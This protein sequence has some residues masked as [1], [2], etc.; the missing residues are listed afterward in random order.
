MV[1]WKSIEMRKLIFIQILFF[2][3]LSNS[4]SQRID[5]TSFKS[6]E[7]KEIKEYKNE[8]LI[9]ASSFKKNGQLAYRWNIKE[10]VLES[11]DAISYQDT[12]AE[13]F[14]DNCSEYTIY[15]HYGNGP[16]FRIENYL[17]RKRH[18]IYEK[19]ERNG[20]LSV[21][22]QF[23][24][25]KKV[26]IWTYYSSEGKKDR[27]VHWF[28]SNYNSKGI[29]I[30][31]TII[32]TFALLLFI[33]LVGYVI[34]K[35]YSYAW[36]YYFYSISSFLIL[37]SLF[38]LSVYLDRSTLVELNAQIRPYLETIL[39][40]IFVFLIG[41]SLVTTILRKK[42][43]VKLYVSIPILLISIT[44]ELWLI[45]AFELAGIRVV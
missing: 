6:G 45:V 38:V 8:E 1:H 27:H 9:K 18:G 3:S 14:K 24:N 30:D 15:Q 25:W 37:I 44:T 28:H 19:Y 32:P 26:G 21:R 13:Y 41:I 4:Y 31:Y 7:T 29:S 12:L 5:T 10:R 33:V 2:F 23:A 35:I 20:K 34:T 11:F 36:F 42:T 22:G 40:S 39:K 17:N 43:N 16:L